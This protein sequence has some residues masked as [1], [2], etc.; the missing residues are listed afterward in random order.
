MDVDSL[1]GGQTKAGEMDLQFIMQT[2]KLVPIGRCLVLPR[3][4][5]ER[6]DIRKLGGAAA[7]AGSTWYAERAPGGVQ[8]KTRNLYF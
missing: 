8:V 1:F 3:G 7:T 2:T 6:Y 5:W 4:P